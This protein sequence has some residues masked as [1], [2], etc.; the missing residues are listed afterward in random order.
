MTFGPE[1]VNPEDT[2]AIFKCPCDAK[3]LS[4]SVLTLHRKRCHKINE[5]YQEVLEEFD[6]LVE[7]A[8]DSQE[9]DNVG[10]LIESL[11]RNY[12]ER[13]G[14]KRARVHMSTLSIKS[15]DVSM[16]EVKESFM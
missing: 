11:D 13:F 2:S 14:Q 9:A 4:G 16:E 7:E 12:E 10:A 6:R 5:R 1:A 3:L 8:T 15:Q